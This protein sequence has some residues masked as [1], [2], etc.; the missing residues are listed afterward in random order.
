MLCSRDRHCSDAV[1]LQIGL[2]TCKGGSALRVNELAL[3]CCQLMEGYLEKK[4][5]GH[6]TEKIWRK[7]FCVFE[8]ESQLFEVFKSTGA[9]KPDIAA[10]FVT[11]FNIP[12]REGR[13]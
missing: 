6:I 12:N 10:K 5:A 9:P 7:R 8:A 4:G 2:A 3:S 1:P 13:R 11:I